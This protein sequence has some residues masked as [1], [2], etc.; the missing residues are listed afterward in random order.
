MR[1]EWNRT[2]MITS[3]VCLIVLVVFFVLGRQWFLQ[4]INEEL[5]ERKSTLE[6]E[7]KVLSAMESNQEPDEREE[8]LTS[9]TLQ[10]QLPV[11]PL[12]DQLL[13]GLDRAESISTSLINQ[14]G[15]DAFETNLTVKPEVEED[16]EED[17]EA[18]GAG[19]LIE[20]LQ[21]MQFSIDMTS[22]NYE[23][24]MKFLTELKSL[25]RITQIESIQFEAPG[26][27]SSE[28]SYSLL[29]NSYYLP[30]YAD[31]ANEAPQYHYGGGSNK[32]NPFTDETVGTN[33]IEEEDEAEVENEEGEL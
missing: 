9:R 24:M 30:A 15:I 14:V 32:V 20:G 4:P 28:V 1:V 13:I 31:L 18:E 25:P 27:D 33:A 22:E 2:S 3:V 11:I 19:V 23:E 21:T 10:Q 26:E 5:Q 16:N 29:L 12:L 7:R 6:T 17:Q 8:I